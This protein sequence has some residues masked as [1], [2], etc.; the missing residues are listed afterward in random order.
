[1]GPAE[2]VASLKELCAEK[3]PRLT[4][5][6]I[7]AW[8]ERIGGYETNAELIAFAKKMKARQFARML[9]FEDEDS[10]LRIKRLWSF[11]DAARGRRFYADIL[12][13][14][15][16]QRKRLD[17]AVCPVRQAT[18]GRAQ[19]HGRLFRRPAVLRLLSR[20][21]RGGRRRGGGPHAG[22]AALSGCVSSGPARPAGRH[23]R[24]SIMR[25]RG[26][27]RMDRQ[28]GRLRCKPPAARAG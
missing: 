6:E 15:E 18:A 28:A 23:T 9:E 25:R 24:P 3:G 4:T 26:P 21:T 13:M 1:M 5:E 22:Q 19:G 8:I 14:P 12:E 10:G 16:E 27:A 7:V 20:R 2:I 17:P 11:H